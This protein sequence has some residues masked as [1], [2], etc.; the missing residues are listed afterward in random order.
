[1]VL[2][3]RDVVGLRHLW[4]SA[5]FEKRVHV[6]EGVKAGVRNAELLQERAQPFL[7]NLFRGVRPTVLVDEEKSGGWHPRAGAPSALL[8]G[9]S[10]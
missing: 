3:L 9:I 4:R 8:K 7:D 10:G 5:A 1:M 2:G 6:S